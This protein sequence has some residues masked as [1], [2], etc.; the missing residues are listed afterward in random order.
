AERGRDRLLAARKKVR[1]AMVFC[2]QM[3]LQAYALLIFS[4]CTEYGTAGPMILFGIQM[5]ILPLIWHIVHI[6]LHAGRSKPA[7]RRGGGG[8]RAGAR[9]I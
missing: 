1:W 7:A 8:Q 4:V 2:A 9:V 6:E 5:T 3:S